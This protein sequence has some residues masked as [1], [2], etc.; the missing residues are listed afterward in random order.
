MAAKVAAMAGLM[1]ASAAYAQG[2]EAR[3]ADATTVSKAS[4]SA[5]DTHSADAA[6]RLADR[7]RLNGMKGKSCGCSPCW[8]P[9]A[10]P[11]MPT[12]GVEA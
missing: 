8:G 2:S 3:T 12:R 10:P 1:A 4:P 7:V 5:A 6:A 9:P 11:E